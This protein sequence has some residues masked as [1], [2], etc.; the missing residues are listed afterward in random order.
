MMVNGDDSTGL[1]VICYIMYV[2]LCMMAWIQQLF[3]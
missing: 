3:V 1:V 2:R